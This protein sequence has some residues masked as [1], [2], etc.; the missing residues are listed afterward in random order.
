MKNR[1]SEGFTVAPEFMEFPSFL[2]CMGRKPTKAHTIDRIDP[3]DT[4][5]APGKCRWLGKTGQ[6]RNRRGTIKFVH[7]HMPGM[8]FFAPQIA[9]MHGIKENTVRAHRRQGWT[10]QEIIENR[11][12]P[13]SATDCTPAAPKDTRGQE[14]RELAQAFVA[15][16]EAA[17]PDFVGEAVNGRRTGQAKAF[18][19]TRGDAARPVMMFAVA[20]WVAFTKRAEIEAGAFKSPLYPSLDYFFR[21]EQVAV[22]MWRD[23]Q[24]T[25]VDIFNTPSPFADPKPARTTIKPAVTVKLSKAE[26]AAKFAETFA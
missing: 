26:L 25:A 11:R 17:N 23:A 22:R 16:A 5:Y 15:E 21:F 13:A 14:A 4:E 9:E 1:R 2:C 24:K 19:Q 3:F 6:T 7:P 8:V 12:M 18:I 10:D 20:N